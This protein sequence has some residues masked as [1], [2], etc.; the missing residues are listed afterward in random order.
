[1]GVNMQNVTRFGIYTF[2]SSTASQEIM[3]HAV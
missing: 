2:A 1:M 3:W